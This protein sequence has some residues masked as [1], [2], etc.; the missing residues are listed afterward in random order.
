MFDKADQAEQTEHAKKELGQ[1]IETL[2]AS[3]KEAT[4]EDEVRIKRDIELARERLS[5]LE[6]A[7]AKSGSEDVDGQVQPGAR[8]K[9]HRG[10]ATSVQTHQ[11]IEAVNDETLSDQV[12]RPESDVDR[13]EKEIRDGKGISN[14]N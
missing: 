2:E 6:Q 13:K 12:R 14:E 3:L 8:S 9:P 4:E 5:A 1:Y 10:D 11:F 7:E